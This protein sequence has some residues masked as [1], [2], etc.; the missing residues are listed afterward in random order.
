MF[1]FF[2]DEPKIGI[3]SVK[4]YFQRMKDES[5]YHA[6]LVVQQQLTPSAKQA[7]DA[8][9]PEY[10]IEQ[11]LESELTV[12]IFYHDLVPEHVVMT[13]DEK[14][15]LLARYSLQESQ[16]MKIQATDPVARYLGLKRG[17]MVKIIRASETAGRYIT[18]RLVC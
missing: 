7:L 3:K 16:M 5:I 1:V 12:N 17:Q 9:S 2:P 13:V 18:Y 14:K 15:E 11:F 4:T 6:I 10:I 8:L